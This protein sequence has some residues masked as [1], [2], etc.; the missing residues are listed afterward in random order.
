[1]TVAVTLF[2][3]PQLFDTRTQ[4]DVV[5]AGLTV[6]DEPVAPPIGELVLPDVPMYH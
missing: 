4:Y 6:I 1:M 2:A 3:A 5:L